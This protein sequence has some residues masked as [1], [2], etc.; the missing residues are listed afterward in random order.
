MSL[1]GC[2]VGCGAGVTTG[3]SGILIVLTSVVVVLTTSP[4]TT[5]KLIVRVRIVRCI[6]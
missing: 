5:E 6:W 4:F 1:N 3:S 2:F